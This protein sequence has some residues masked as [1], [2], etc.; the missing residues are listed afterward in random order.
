[1][2]LVFPKVCHSNHKVSWQNHA[3]D[4]CVKHSTYLAWVSFLGMSSVAV[5]SSPLF[6][7]ACWRDFVVTAGGTV[8]LPC[9]SLY[10]IL[11][12]YAKG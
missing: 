6:T 12:K 2:S 3:V 4:L 5:R 9:W 8:A 7:L 10:S 1:M 11:L